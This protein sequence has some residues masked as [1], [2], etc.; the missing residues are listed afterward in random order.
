MWNDVAETEA[1]LAAAGYLPSREI[2]MAVFLADRMEKPILVEG[3]AGVGKTELAKALATDTHRE[4]IRLQCY[5]G[6]DE[7]KALYEWEYAKQLLYTQI[8]KDKIGETISSARTLEEAADR[9]SGSDAVFFSR[10]FLVPRPLLQALTSEQPSLLL[11]DEID[12]ADPEFEAFLLE[13]LSD[14]A[15][16]VPELGTITARSIPRVILTS[17]NARELS[18]ALK[19]RCLHL[20]IDYPTLERELAIIRS[21]IPG[22]SQSLAASVV[23]AV[24]K[25][26]SMDMK[27]SPSISETLD[28]ARSLAILNADTLTPELVGETLNLV[29]KYEADVARAREARADIALASQAS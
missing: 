24:Q 26:R 14:F 3:P 18:D 8:L 2:A 22:I 25:I 11:I 7:S 4:L 13:L 12:K 5:E 28:W 1:S 27:K 10:R 20:W 16:T 21:R 19:R 29:L 17:N 15:V 23:R 6:L 9:I